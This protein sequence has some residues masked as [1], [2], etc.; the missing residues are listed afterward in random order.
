MEAVQLRSVPDSSEMLRSND[1]GEESLAN[2]A[3]D[4]LAKAWRVSSH[5]TLSSPFRLVPHKA[6]NSQQRRYHE[7][8]SDWA[9]SQ[10]PLAKGLSRIR[11]TRRADDTN[12]N[13]WPASRPS[14]H[15]SVLVHTEKQV[16]RRGRRLEGDLDPPF[17]RTKSAA[18]QDGEEEGV[19]A[20]N[21]KVARAAGSSIL[22]F[23]QSSSIRFRTECAR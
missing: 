14:T 21:E 18:D 3:F 8:L 13:S 15:A 17:L 16:P 10:N 2:E 7:P 4:R 6:V 1:A 11:K 9:P 20:V 12:S 22:G 5:H 19:W 23:V